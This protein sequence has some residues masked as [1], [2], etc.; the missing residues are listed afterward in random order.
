MLFDNHIFVIILE[1]IQLIGKCNLKNE[2]TFTYEK[3]I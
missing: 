2:N 1:E 3:Y